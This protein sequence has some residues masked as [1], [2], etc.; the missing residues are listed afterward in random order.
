[1]LKEYVISVPVVKKEYWDDL[2]SQ[3]VPDYEKLM[4][5]LLLKP[6][7]KAYEILHWEMPDI[8]KA[9]IKT[10]FSFIKKPKATA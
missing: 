7:E 5:N 10:N 2:Q 3:V 1:M 9:F 8:K 6:M 4:Q